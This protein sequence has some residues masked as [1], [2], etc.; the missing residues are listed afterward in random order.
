MEIA[1]HGPGLPPGTEEKVF[2]KFFRA[3]PEGM[4]GSR[5]GMGLGLAI[6]RGIVEAHGGKITAENRPGGGSVF[7]FTLPIDGGA[8]YAGRMSM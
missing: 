8:A 4:D 7:R 6:C 1:D 3:R 5:R 2:Q